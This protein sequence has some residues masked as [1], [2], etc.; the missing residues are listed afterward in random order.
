[1]ASLIL[2]IFLSAFIFE[3]I[4]K[5]LNALTQ[6][7]NKIKQGYLEESVA[8]PESDDEMRE[9][10]LIFNGMIDKLNRS[11]K[12]LHIAS[13]ELIKQYDLMKARTDTQTSK[14]VFKS[15]FW[16]EISEGMRTPL[17]IVSQ[18]IE[19]LKMHSLTDGER[20]KIIDM[21]MKAMD[22]LKYMVTI[23]MDLS[24]EKKAA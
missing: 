12:Q 2:V 14:E 21:A 1:M 23:Y 7:V 4:L 15:D 6:T 18:A 3:R 8:V 11:R 5:P 9:F 24:S 19:D 20:D 17:A 13:Q 22:R 10:I 16:G